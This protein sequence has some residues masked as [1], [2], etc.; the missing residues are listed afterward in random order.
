[1]AEQINHGRDAPDLLP[2]TGICPKH[3]GMFRL[4]SPLARLPFWAWLL[5]ALCSAC[6]A[7]AQDPAQDPAQAME[8]RILDVFA[9]NI[10]ET[11]LSRDQIPAI[12]RPLFIGVPDAS[13]SL[14]PG[15]P[16]FVLERADPAR[17]YPQPALVWHEVVNDVINGE[18]VSVTYCPL[19]GSVAGYAGAVGLFSTGFGTTGSLINNNTVLYDRSTNSLWPQILGKAVSGPLKGESLSRLDLV[20]TTWARA[21]QLYPEALVL[22]NTT[23]YRRSYGRDPYGSYESGV[24]YYQ[25]DTIVHPLT[26]EDHRLPPKERILGVLSG[27]LPMAVV[28]AEVVRQ[29]VVNVDAGIT[30]LV[31]LYDAE[32]DTVRLFERRVRSRDLTFVL[33]EGRIFDAETRSQWNA[34]GRSVDG[35]SQGDALAPASAMDCMWF[36]WAAFHP[37]TRIAPGADPLASF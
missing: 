14:D 15:D 37:D 21:R 20:W 17:I 23:G 3:D 18:P 9:D 26:T 12:D 29:Q 5:A 30:P 10:V 7:L 28:R 6:P 31:A 35:V 32:L 13:L 34:R 1:M 22:S 27:D 19:T 4:P 8:D 25:N 36:A 24:T 11:G 2:D 16:V 33:T